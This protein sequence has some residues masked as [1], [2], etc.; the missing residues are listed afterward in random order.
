M[1]EQHVVEPRDI[2]RRETT[3]SVLLW[4]G[5]LG[6]P[7]AWF[8]QVVVAPD[9]AEIIC[10]PGAEAS[11]RGEVYGIAVDDLLTG[12]NTVLTLVAVAGLVASLLCWRRLRSAVDAT[13]G[14]RASW[15]AIAAIMVSVLFLVSIV[16]G[17]IPLLM[18]EPCVTVP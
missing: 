6:A 5:L 16:V 9:L 2:T 14:R 12:F 4:F 7:L 17:Y 11:G 8:T 13:T 1:S 15:M 18:L 10:Y 3:G